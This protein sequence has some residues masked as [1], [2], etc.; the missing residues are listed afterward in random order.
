MFTGNRRNRG[1]VQDV[2]NYFNALTKGE[3]HQRPIIKNENQEFILGTLENTVG[4]D[5]L[6]ND[7]MV[8]LIQDVSHLSN[9]DVNMS[10]I[11]KKMEN[12]SID[13]SEF[14]TSNMAVV[15]ETTASMNQVSDAIANSTQ[16]LENLSTKASLLIDINKQN[17]DQLEEV[18]TIKDMVIKHTDSVSEKIDM[19]ADI[20]QNVDDIVSAVGNIAEQTNLLSLDA[21]IEA[22][23]AGDYGKGFAVV[24][25]EIRKLAEGTKEKLL[26]MQNFTKIIRT[27]TDDVSSS[28]EESKNSIELMNNKVEQVNETFLDNI[29]NLETTVDGV[30][31]LSSMMQEVNASTEE[32]NQAMNSIATDSEKINDMTKEILYYSKESIEYS[33]E[34]SEIDTDMADIV[35]QMTGNLNKGT[36][37]ISND[38]LIG[39]IERAVVSHI[40]WVD[41]L[42][43]IVDRKELSPIQSDGNKCE[44]GHYYKCMDIENER[45]REKWLSI[46]PIHKELHS[47]AK[48]VNIAIANNDIGKAKEECLHAESIS[49][50]IINKLKE[51]VNDITHMNKVGERVF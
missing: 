42:K 13:L 10:F 32:V 46:D 15:E 24:A 35:K 5:K 48:E 29:E 8:R 38:L 34:I 47:K 4:R 17:H 51:I 12:I 1:E 6:N 2:V 41:K 16:I 49:K 26:E 27:A 50:D 36:Y 22:A 9:F 40:S 37:P 18:G 25:D 19:L 28:V 3:D 33:K 31:D 14:G 44:F 23:R 39:F 45:L 7:L 21:S 43:S 11:S 30:M 20:S